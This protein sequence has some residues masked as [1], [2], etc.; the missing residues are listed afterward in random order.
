L[1]EIG[2]DFVELSG[3]KDGNRHRLRLYRQDLQ[4]PYRLIS[5][6]IATPPL[7]RM[8]LMPLQPVPVTADPAGEARP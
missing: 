4:R 7:E 6:R 5:D 8:I 1:Q 2:P 3:T